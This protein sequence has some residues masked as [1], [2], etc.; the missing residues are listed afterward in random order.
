VKD[1]AEAVVVDPECPD[2]ARLPQGKM[3]SLLPI[4]QR[5]FRV[6]PSFLLRAGARLLAHRACHETACSMGAGKAA[7]DPT[8]R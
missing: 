1:F 6:K 5:L 2:G 7:A 4:G 8:P 3:P